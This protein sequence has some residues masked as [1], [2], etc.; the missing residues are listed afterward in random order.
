LRSACRDREGISLRSS[1][2]LCPL[3]HGA[4]NSCNYCKSPIA[5]LQS[6]S[7]VQVRSGLK[8]RGSG[9]IFIGGPLWRISR[10]HRL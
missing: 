1:K 7:T 10:C 8:D 9:A 3:D 6:S 4:V 2:A 5:K